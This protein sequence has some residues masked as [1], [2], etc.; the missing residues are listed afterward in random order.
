MIGTI[1]L[2]FKT[3]EGNVYSDDVDELDSGIFEYVILHREY[4][5]IRRFQWKNFNELLKSIRLRFILANL[6]RFPGHFKSD[7]LYEKCMIE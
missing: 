3:I 4:T 5:S 6:K 7:C 1:S 2:V